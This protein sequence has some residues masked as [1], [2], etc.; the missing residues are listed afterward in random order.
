MA[1]GASARLRQQHAQPPSVARA[2]PA[3][4]GG[5]CPAVPLGIWCIVG[6]LASMEHGKVSLVFCLCSD[7][8]YLGVL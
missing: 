5:R 7:G 1:D 2:R 6:Q 8:N 3:G 4:A